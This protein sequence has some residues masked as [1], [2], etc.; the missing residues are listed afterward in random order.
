MADNATLLETGPRGPGLG[1]KCRDGAGEWRGRLAALFPEAAN[2]AASQEETGAAGWR[3]PRD[4]SVAVRAI[5]VT[6]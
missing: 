2:L 1:G 4:I 6:R 5:M 3:R